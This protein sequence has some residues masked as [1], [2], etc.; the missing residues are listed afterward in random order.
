MDDRQAMER[1]VEL[2]RRSR[3][4]PNPRVGCVILD[5]SGRV[6]GEGFHVA[7]GEPH[8]E[9]N[10]LAAARG[11]GTAA[12]AII[13]LEP[14]THTGRTPPCVQALLEAGIRRVV[15][16]S[17]DPDSRV[18]G[19]GLDALAE[20]GIEVAL[21][22]PDITELDPGYAHHRKHGRP[23]IVLKL[24]ATLDG[25]TATATGESQWITGEA[26]RRRV[27]EMRAE[28]DALVVGVG[29]VIADNPRLTVRLDGYEGPQPRS[30]VIVGRRGLP[31]GHLLADPL[32]YGPNANG[33]AIAMRGD[34]GV[35]LH[36]VAYDLGDRG[37]LDV[38]VEG[39]AKLAASWWNA[40]LV[41]EVVLFLAGRIAG[42]V[43]RPMFDG[44]FS[45]LDSARR[46]EIASV[47]PIGDD[48]M[49][50]GMVA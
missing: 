49:V 32:V 46:V 11:H 40:G 5:Q 1:A 28:A 27:H 33:G 7:A 25:Q 10:A 9:R 50:R 41:D 31:D 48:L 37:Y 44:V 16:G 20:S 29:T 4:H 36:G 43:G 35:D 24:A 47:D 23:R 12:T 34:R 8:A 17:V 45:Q 22:G 13:T 26:A 15:V 39:G 38:M 2:A 42:G 6:I 21:I 30:V 18:G 3:P 14:C 19:A